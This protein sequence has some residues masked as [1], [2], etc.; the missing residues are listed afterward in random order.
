VLRNDPS[1]SPGSVPCGDHIL[2]R[3]I[4]PIS[5][6]LFKEDLLGSY[7][8]ALSAGCSPLHGLIPLGKLKFKVVYI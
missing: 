7:N 5:P 6:Y 2:I 8:L 4:Y 3:R 1:D